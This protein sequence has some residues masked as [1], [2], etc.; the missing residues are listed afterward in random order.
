MSFATMKWYAFSSGSAKKRAFGQPPVG[1][2]SASASP[3]GDRG[4]GYRGPAFSEKA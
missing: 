1:A 2:A 3:G 4:R